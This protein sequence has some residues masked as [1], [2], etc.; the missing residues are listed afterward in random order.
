MVKRKV[1]KK[2]ARAIREAR[3]KNLRKARRVLK[4]KRGKK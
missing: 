3:L 1:K 4:A 2:S